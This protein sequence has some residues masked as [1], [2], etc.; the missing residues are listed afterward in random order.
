MHLFR[1]LLIV[2]SAFT[3]ATALFIN[4]H[5]FPTQAR[6]GNTCNTAL[7]HSKVHPPVVKFKEHRIHKIFPRGGAVSKIKNEPVSRIGS[8]LKDKFFW[9]LSCNPDEANVRLDPDEQGRPRFELIH[10]SSAVRCAHNRVETILEDADEKIKTAAAKCK[11]KC[12][13]RLA[14]RQHR[15]RMEHLNEDDMALSTAYE[16]SSEGSVGK[17]RVYLTR[18]K[19]S[20]GSGTLDSGGVEWHRNALFA[21]GSMIT[22]LSSKIMD[23]QGFTWQPHCKITAINHVNHRWEVAWLKACQGHVQCRHRKLLPMSEGDPATIVMDECKRLCKCQ[24]VPINGYGRIVTPQALWPKSTGRKQNAKANDNY[25]PDVSNLSRRG[26]VIRIVEGL[27]RRKQSASDEQRPQQQ[28][29]QVQLHLA[30]GREPPEE[31]RTKWVKLSKTSKGTTEQI[32]H[33]YIRCIPEIVHVVRRDRAMVSYSCS[34]NVHCR[35]GTVWRKNG[36]I[37]DQVLIECRKGCSCHENATNDPSIQ[38]PPA[39]SKTT[40][41]GEVLVCRQRAVQHADN[42]GRRVT[43][44]CAASVKCV[45]GDIVRKYPA[46]RVSVLDKCKRICHCENSSR[47]QKRTLGLEPTAFKQNTGIVRRIESGQ[48]GNS[49]K[50]G[51]KMSASPGR[52]PPHKGQISWNEE[53]PELLATSSLNQDDIDKLKEQF[54]ANITE[55]LLVKRYIGEQ[56]QPDNHQQSQ[57]D[58]PSLQ[59]P[60]F[61]D[62]QTRPFPKDTMIIHKQV[63]Q[64]SPR[65]APE[66]SAHI[67]SSNWVLQC[68][69]DK[70]RL[71]MS[72]KINAFK[73]INCK[74]FVRCEQTLIVKKTGLTPDHIFRTCQWKCLCHRETSLPTEIIPSRH[75]FHI[76]EPRSLDSLYGLQHGHICKKSDELGEETVSHDHQPLGLGLDAS[77]EEIGEEEG[78]TKS[79]QGDG[80]L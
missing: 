60:A 25:E 48:K 63:N 67:R 54:D 80:K 78:E 71:Q 64:A 49:E 32:H 30:Y 21:R 7:E 4:S 40:I 27:K 17:Y 51:A 11:K 57:P 46:A 58:F 36:F 38:A 1:L 28:Q 50:S 19:K 34:A 8:K 52:Q 68:E 59:P 76:V 6:D 12:R 20:H 44:E 55:Q 33:G 77:E 10:C 2:L 13:C 16:T 24:R 61:L 42:T 26:K 56:D 66:A 65:I 47:I 43:Y 3:F 72:S 14:I 37:G 23:T 35:F 79:S 18:W 62:M 73:I 29:I 5:R 9:Q 15:K 53:K 22:K 39:L 69:T 41:H 31:L 74:I 70:L 45:N 75:A